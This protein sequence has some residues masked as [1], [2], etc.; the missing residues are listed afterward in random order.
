MWEGFKSETY[1][2]R[3]LLP[4]ESPDSANSVW[5]NDFGVAKLCEEILRQ[6]SLKF[7]EAKNV[8]F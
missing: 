8:L 7:I 1:E 6:L 5:F 4:N 3:P 2:D